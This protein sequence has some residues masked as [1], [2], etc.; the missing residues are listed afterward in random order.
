MENG[1]GNGQI[2]IAHLEFSYVFPGV[3][4]ALRVF[5]YTLNQRSLKFSKQFFGQFEL[6]VGTGRCTTS[7]PTYGCF[8]SWE[9]RQKNS[10]NGT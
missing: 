9:S 2:F 10:F 8:G 1:H 7:E 5:I 6:D 4:E 3:R